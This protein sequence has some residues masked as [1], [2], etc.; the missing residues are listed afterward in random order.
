MKSVPNGTLVVTIHAD[1]RLETHSIEPKEDRQVLAATQELFEAMRMNYQ[2]PQEQDAVLTTSM[3]SLI[4]ALRRRWPREAFD[5]IDPAELRMLLFESF[6]VGH[7]PPNEPVLS[8]KEQ[9]R[10]RAHHSVAAIFQGS[11]ASLQGKE[12]GCS[13]PHHFVHLGVQRGSCEALQCA[14]HRHFFPP[15][16][17]PK[18][19]ES[20]RLI[21]LPSVLVLDIYNKGISLGPDGPRHFGLPDM[22]DLK[23]YIH[24]SVAA[25]EPAPTM[26]LHGAIFRTTREGSWVAAVRLIMA[27]GE[28]QWW[29]LEAS[30]STLLAADQIAALGRIHTLVYTAAG[31]DHSWPQ[32]RTVG[33][34]IEEKMAPSASLRHAVQLAAPGARG[35]GRSGCD[36]CAAMVDRLVASEQGLQSQLAEVSQEREEARKQ[37][38]LY[39]A[40]A[41]A[42]KAQVLSGLGTVQWLM[43]QGSHRLHDNK[44]SRL[45]TGLKELNAR[46][47]EDGEDSEESSPS[48]G[49]NPSMAGQPLR[50][51]SNRAEGPAPKPA[52]D[53]AWARQQLVGLLGQCFT[54]RGGYWS[55][56][57]CSEGEVRQYRAGSA[58]PRGA[59]DGKSSFSLG[60]YRATEVK[61]VQATLLEFYE[62]GS[63]CGDL[64]GQERSTT[65]RWQCGSVGPVSSA[66]Q[67]SVIEAKYRGR[68]RLVRAAVSDITEPSPCNY[69]IE[70]YTQA[71]C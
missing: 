41:E 49:D 46:H 59:P 19:Q 58:S 35:G 9:P 53:A 3:R 5:T 32:H 63:A 47:G 61:P 13:P 37:A 2:S 6:R 69:L 40:E 12:G 27:D 24:G 26:E 10:Q 4:V 22:I 71:L 57:I 1:D 33:L 14:L 64:R 15:D 66:H 21:Q 55:Y 31:L 48:I 51:E 36:E 60:R 11:V 42:L 16:S 8:D 65:V 29:H 28:P 68:G 30:G 70:V 54:Y 20:T 44:L 7:L 43:D 18:E 39:K 50:P 34:K 62:G 67:G 38:A 25:G 45:L 17:E 52:R 56:E 23:P